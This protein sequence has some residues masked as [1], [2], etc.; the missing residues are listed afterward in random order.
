MPHLQG[1][2]NKEQVM[3]VKPVSKNSLGSCAILGAS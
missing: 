2:I 3:N 1:K